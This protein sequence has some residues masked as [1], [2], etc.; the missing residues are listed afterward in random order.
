MSIA[1]RPTITPTVHVV[2][3]DDSFRTAIARLLKAAGY[4]VRTYSSATEFI[5]SSVQAGPGCVLLDM[6]MP[7]GT[8]LD[9]QAALAKRDDR[10]PLIFVSGQ[11]TIP[12]TVRA[13]Q[14][15]AA[16]FLTKPVQRHAL[17]KA[18]ESAVAS[19]QQ[20]RSSRDKEHETDL[21]YRALTP[22]QRA[23][24]DAVVTG[25]LNKQI[26]AEL[27][28]AERTVK[29]HRAK[30]MKKMHAESVAELVRLSVHL[31][32]AGGTSRARGRV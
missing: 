18:V 12:D 21:C 22:R 10:L 6:F 3:D 19:D 20:A 16:D 14:A 5:H 27:G 26:A 11:G 2:D 17:L 30:V 32:H 8:G 15:G 24:F 31:Q 4:D 29:A 28:V 9:V 1:S 13:M 23:V 25:K 7:D